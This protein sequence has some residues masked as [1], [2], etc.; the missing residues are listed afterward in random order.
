MLLF[1]C[2]TGLYSKNLSN[3]LFYSAMT[4]TRFF[5][6]LFLITVFCRQGVADQHDYL[7]QLILK[8]KEIRLAADPQWHALLHYQK[9]NLGLGYKSL[10]VSNVFFNAK[11]GN[12]NPESELEATLTNFFNTE[13]REEAGSTEPYQ[14]A[15]KAR[16][17]WLNKKLNFD[18][19]KMPLVACER[20]DKWFSAI[21]AIGVTLIFPSAYINNPASAFG[22]T[23]LRLDQAGQNEKNRLLA[24]TANFA[25]E[26]G[27]EDGFSYAFKGVFGG[28][29]GYFSVAPYYEKVK[30]YGDIERRD[31]WEYPLN[32]S[33]E[34]TD[35]LLAHLWELRSIGFPYYYFDQN[36]SYYLL[37]LLEAARPSLRLSEQFPSWVI[38]VD[39]VRETLKRETAASNPVF[40]A[41]AVSSLQQRIAEKDDQIR[42]IAKKLAD[43]DTTLDSAEFQILNE[44][45]KAESIDLAY[46]Y[47]NFKI[48]SGEDKESILQQ[49]A[50]KLL[51]A[52]SQLAHISNL[53]ITTPEI[54]PDQGHSTSTIS[55]AAGIEDE[56]WFYETRIRPAYHDLLD[57]LAGFNK[58]A[59]IELLELV[60]RQKEE[61]SPKLERAMILDIKSYSPR[62]EFIKPVSWNLDFGFQ[63]TK[64]SEDNRELLFQLNAGAGAAWNLSDNIFS[65]ALLN[66]STLSDNDIENG[67]AAGISPRLGVIYS[68][69]AFWQ[70][71]PTFAMKEFVA[72]DRGSDIIFGL[73]QSF[74][75]NT[76]MAVRLSAEH[77][78]TFGEEE[79][80][81]SISYDFYL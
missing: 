60:L 21:D 31:I 41:S 20:F 36:C 12:S 73:E 78:K 15:F 61:S 77:K 29:D 65:Y 33:K 48:I 1:L 71:S 27:G 50:Y 22:H 19:S 80:L 66:L 47:L 79:N 81:F 46:E 39:S 17:K 57:P 69:Y 11:D 55:L 45:E 53:D 74:S 62:N 13:G 5:S 68:P 2:V 38:P 72:G 56:Q 32:F 75:I 76:N 24:Y 67:Y 43:A 9:Q 14:C 63:R 26:T 70:I 54:R 49:R 59:Q 4:L 35:F 37:G 8:S 64:I 51:K 52:R 58:G 7:N 3:H 18:T 40:R 30:L 34:E 16:F 28:Y 23:L 10:A 6:L 42:L 44:V 25:A